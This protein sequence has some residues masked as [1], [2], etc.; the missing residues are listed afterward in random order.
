[1]EKSLEGKVALITGGGSGMGR[2]SALEFATLGAKVVVADY[3]ADGGE[4]TA[5]VIRDKGGEAT[6]VQVDVTNPGTGSRRLI[7][8]VVDT[9]G[10]L[11]FAHNNAGIEGLLW[12][13]RR[14]HCG[15]LEPGHRDQPDRRVA[16]HQV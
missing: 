1:M 3:V 13:H 14:M 10:R 7:K 9:Y 16:V 6:F 15:Q 4:R 11:D 12:S 5:A 2:A 8:K